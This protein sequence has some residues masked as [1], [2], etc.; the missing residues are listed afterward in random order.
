MAV[1]KHGDLTVG[2]L[3][4]CLHNAGGGGGGNWPPCL[5]LYTEQRRKNSKVLCPVV[6]FRCSVAHIL[7]LWTLCIAKG[8]HL[9]VSSETS[10]LLTIVPLAGKSWPFLI[11]ARSP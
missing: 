4:A 9:S 2:F 10:S 11:F 1:S 3:T 5:D 7:Q 8:L 6:E